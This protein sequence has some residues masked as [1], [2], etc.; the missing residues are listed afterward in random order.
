MSKT[1]AV[2]ELLQLEKVGEHRYRVRHE[3]DA[4]TDRDVVFGGQILGQMIMASDAECGGAKEVKSIH[5]I[6]ARAGTYG[7]PM[8]LE[9]DSMHAG[10]AFV[11]DF[12][13]VS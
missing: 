1:E 8:D 5:A 9:V 11:A 13:Y 4:T 10:R 2:P 6:F 12:E 3:H 7:Q